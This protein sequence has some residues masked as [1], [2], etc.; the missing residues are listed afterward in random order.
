MK[1]IIEK[2]EVQFVGWLIAMSIAIAVPFAVNG[3]R[4]DQLET[5]MK[6][7]DTLHQELTVTLTDMQ[8]RLATIQKDIEYLK[9]K[10]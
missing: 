1:E 9:L 7:V 3:N 10:K 8:I 6:K 4:I 5:Q 2:K